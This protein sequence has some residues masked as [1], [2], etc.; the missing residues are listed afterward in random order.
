[1]TSLKDLLFV[2]LDLVVYNC[3]AKHNFYCWNVFFISRFKRTCFNFFLHYISALNVK[4]VCQKRK[5]EMLLF[6]SNIFDI[7]AQKIAGPLTTYI[8]FLYH[9]LLSFTLGVDLSCAPKISIFSIHVYT[10]LSKWPVKII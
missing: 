4:F 1:M 5:T 7:Y 10:T 6:F 3:I 8:F 2:L 9:L